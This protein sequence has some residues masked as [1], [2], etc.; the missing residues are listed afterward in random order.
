MYWQKRKN[1]SGKIYYSFVQWNPV[2]RKNIRLRT[3]EVPADIN[4]DAQADA[5]CRLRET[6]DEASKLRIQRKLAWQ[7]KFYDFNELI[8]IFEI[9]VKKRAP[10]SWKGPLYY[11][12][13]YAFDFFLNEKQCNNLNNWPLYFEEFRD[14]LMTVKTGKKT[15]KGGLAYS[16]RNN[17]IG[18]V[19]LFLDVMFKKGKCSQLPKCQKFPRHLLAK[20]DTSHIISLDEAKIIHQRLNDLEPTGVAGDFFMVLLNTG[21]RLGEG[22]SLSLADFFPGTPDKKIISGALEKHGLKCLGYISLE[23]QLANTI[24]PRNIDGSVPRKPLKGRKRIEAKAGRVVPVLD[25]ETFNILAKRFNEQTDLLAE[26]RFGDSKSDYLLFD[27]LDKNK[28]SRLLR[29]AYENTRFNHKSPHCARHT[30]ATNFAGL[31]HADTGLCRLVLGHKDE[32]TTLGYVHLFE[33]INRQARAKE[34]VKVKID[35]ID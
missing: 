16:S 29:K 4:T 33:Q 30:F 21:F 22:L 24:R 11:L 13:Q 15:K 23:S 28:F 26:R 31:T 18:A 12:Q 9:E 25:K 35:L 2:S 19:N 14:W 27:G 3:S 34:L 10:N 20:R 32:D 1:R 17:V 6:E 8:S 7:N 5:F